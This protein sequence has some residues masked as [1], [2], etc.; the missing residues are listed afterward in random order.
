MVHIVK[1]ILHNAN[2]SDAIKV[3]HENCCLLCILGLRY[4]RFKGYVVL[5]SYDSMKKLIIYQ[6]P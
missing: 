2:S 3:V 4:F 1:L 6:L 5:S